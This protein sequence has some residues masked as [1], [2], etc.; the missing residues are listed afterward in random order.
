MIDVS[1]EELT[2]E[3]IGL[4]QERNLNPDDHVDFVGSGLFYRIERN[5]H[6]F[7]LRGI[8]TDN[9]NISMQDLNNGDEYL[10]EKLRLTDADQLRE[11]LFFPTQNKLWAKSL[12]RENFNRR[13]PFVEDKV[14]NIT[15]PSYNWWFNANYTQLAVYFYS[16][17]DDSNE[18]VNLG[19][20]GDFK[21]AMEMLWKLRNSYNRTRGVIEYSCQ[22]S[23]LYVEVDD[24]SSELLINLRSLLLKGVNLF[25]PDH[26][27][28]P[29]TGE[30]LIK[31]FDQIAFIRR[32]WVEVDRRLK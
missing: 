5:Q 30:S 13:F 26:F 10:V 29:L 18:L 11:I 17:S 9:A 27:D 21:Y 22:K 1:I 16:P 19:P 3:T 20:L 25:R 7:S 24:G 31:Y 12:I 14:L 32:F 28:D 8:Y 6:S 2:K 15:D 4:V 23:G